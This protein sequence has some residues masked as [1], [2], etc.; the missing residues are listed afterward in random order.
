MIEL[1][2]HAAAPFVASGAR[3]LTFFCVFVYTAGK[4]GTFRMSDCSFKSDGTCMVTTTTTTDGT[5]G[6]GGEGI[7]DDARWMTPFSTEIPNCFLCQF[8][9][10]AKKIFSVLKFSIF[11]KVVVD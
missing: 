8:Y 1:V 10:M 9:L 6:C 11:Q 7:V 3:D 4:Q 2:F 5:S